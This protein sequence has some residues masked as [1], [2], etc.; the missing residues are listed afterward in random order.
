MPR[1]T[2]HLVGITDT[3]RGCDPSAGY[4][5]VFSKSRIASEIEQTICNSLQ[6]SLLVLNMSGFAEAADADV[7]HACGCSSS[8]YLELDRAWSY[9]VYE[10]TMCAKHQAEDDDKK[11]QEA[12]RVIADTAALRDA[13]RDFEAASHDL[14]TN[15]QMI[16]K[17]HAKGSP[18]Q[19][20]QAPGIL[21]GQLSDALR[22]AKIRGRWRMC[23]NRYRAFCQHRLSA[24]VGFP[25]PRDTAARR[26]NEYEIQGAAY[27][28]G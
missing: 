16:D 11:E 10:R 21:R 2:Y 28:F 26:H 17:I 19:L 14:E 22:I 6:C 7:T 5:Y 4:R 23:A 9:T 27:R 25:D 15:E 3:S 12:Q 1:S 20:V 24:L 18:H 8:S 13:L